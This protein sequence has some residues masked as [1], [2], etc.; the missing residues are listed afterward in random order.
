MTSC[1]K[2]AFTILLTCSTI[3][4]SIQLFL[5]SRSSVETVWLEILCFKRTENWN[6][7]KYNTYILF[8]DPKCLMVM[9]QNTT[10]WNYVLPHIIDGK[11]PVY[12]VNNYKIYHSHLQ[13][14]PMLQA[15]KCHYFPLILPTGT[16]H[17]VPGT[18][19]NFVGALELM[20]FPLR[21]PEAPNT[22]ERYQI[23]LFTLYKQLRGTPLDFGSILIMFSQ[24]HKQST[25]HVQAMYTTLVCN[26]LLYLR[27]YKMQKTD[28]KTVFLWYCFSPVQKFPLLK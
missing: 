16:L 8:W 21:F 9:V 20:T 13:E 22:R 26:R 18:S 7:S 14:N 27:R 17:F 11:S 28:T 6:R 23:S 2:L 3:A 12:K 4:V 5:S 15:W 1:L 10:F 19:S 24:M 25:Y